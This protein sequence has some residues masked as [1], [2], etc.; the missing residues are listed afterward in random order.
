MTIKFCPICGGLAN[1]S[2]GNCLLSKDCY[3]AING[4]ELSLE[5]IHQVRQHLGV[6]LSTDENGIS[7][8][9]KTDLEE[10][11][12]IAMILLWIMM[13]SG[14]K[15]YINQKVISSI[16]QEEPRRVPE[17]PEL[18]LRRGRGRPKVGVNIPAVRDLVYNRGISQRKVA[19]ALGVNYATLSRKLKEAVE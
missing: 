17:M 2:Y 7:E 8:C 9:Y 4:K 16:G 19:K 1:Y 15:R 6:K 13:P 12:N 3:E 11:G 5:T 10:D 18:I 14:N